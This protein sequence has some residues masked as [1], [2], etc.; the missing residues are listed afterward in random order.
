MGAGHGARL[1][2]RIFPIVSEAFQNPK[3]SLNLSFVT[4]CLLSNI[5]SKG[6]D[7]SECIHK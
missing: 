6:M 5:I 7:I 2:P 4:F 1:L 3:K